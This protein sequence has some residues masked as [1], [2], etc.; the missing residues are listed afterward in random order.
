MPQATGTD[1]Y[2]VLGVSETATQDE[3]KK[4]YRKL[5]K[6]LHPDVNQKNPAA[7]ERFKQVSEAY[8]VVGNEEKRKKYDEM[9]RLGAFGG[10][11]FE[12]HAGTGPGGGP[13]FG[14]GRIDMDLDDLAGFGGLGEILSQMFG[15]ARASPGRRDY[16]GPA[17]GADRVVRVDVPFQAAALGEKVRVRAT[18]L[19]S[20]PRCKGSGAEPG[21][22]VET[23]PQCGGLGTLSFS[24]GSFSVSRP[25][26]R[27]HGRGQ[28]ISDPCERC[29]GDGLVETQRTFEVAIPPGTESGT[30]I[31]L[32]GQGDPSPDGGPP[33][34]LVI[35][36]TVAPDRF[37]VER[38]GLDVVSEVKLNLAQAL[39]GTKLRVRTLR[40]QKVELKIPPGTQT[41]ES[42]RLKGLGIE[43]DGKRGDQIVRVKVELPEKLSE[44][45]RE[46]VEKL[47]ESRGMK[48]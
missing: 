36:A 22:K 24:Q 32:K 18:V 43:K 16:Y 37:F 26:P 46:M 45:E 19:A 7:Q 25:C 42:F 21:T 11:G 2:K 44:E 14:G 12:P 15:G 40:G 34:D 6:Q 29:G 35:E 31:R 39:L 10:F 4:A 38:R 33:G 30:R 41:G 13:G 23:C 3:I 1:Y 9:R 47:A 48:H 27:C 28:I 20:C 5:A 17:R 8:A